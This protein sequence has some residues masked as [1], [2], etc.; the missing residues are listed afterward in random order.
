VNVNVNNQLARRCGLAAACVALFAIAL[1]GVLGYVLA[2]R[3][4]PDPEEPRQTTVIDQ[5][6][7]QTVV[8]QVV[9][10]P[11]DDPGA[12]R[13]AIARWTLL[14][15]L[16]VV[17]LAGAGGWFYGPRLLGA[18][19]GNR[20]VN[21][22]R[23]QERRRLEEVVHEL[24]TP[25]AITSMNL[26]LVKTESDGD[27]LR[28]VDAAHRAVGR[29]S[30]TVQDLAAHGGLAFEAPGTRVVDL[31]T[32][33]R[34]LA[35]EHEGPASTRGVT[36]RVDAPAAVIVV[37]DRQ[38]VRTVV[39]NVL[40]NAVRLSPRGATVTVT[41]RADEN[42]ASVAV[43]DQG[44]GIDPAQH[45]LVFRRNWRGRYETERGDSSGGGTRGLGLTIARQVAE[46]QGGRITVASE[47]GAG[48]IFTLWLPRTAEADPS[49]IV[50]T[51]GIHPAAE[52]S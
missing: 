21:A 33:A 37:A 7:S 48:A 8:T 14:A 47:V 34:G 3:A 41:V 26:D 27:T 45:E 4:E 6:G 22:F 1:A 11:V 2:A 5:T 51:D 19:P 16:F 44:P 24:R 17:P 28:Y 29:M 30:R 20:A 25:L 46:A 36:V 50:A 32:E 35:T 42:W 13:A 18:G 31:V 12:A 43:R 49:T 52:A 10:A 9:A 38:A 15:A 23:E 40:A 39:G